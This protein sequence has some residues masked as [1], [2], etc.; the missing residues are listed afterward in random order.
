MRAWSGASGSPLGGGSKVTT[1][2]RICSTLRPVLADTATA[3]SAGQADGFLDHLLGARDVGRGQVDLVDDGDDLEAVRDGKV[4]IGEGLGFD[5]LA[6]V[7][8]Q[9]RAFTAGERARDFVAEVDVAGSVDE[10]E[11]VGFAVV[12]LVDH[13]DGVGLDGDAAFALEVH[14]VEDLGL[15]LALGQASGEL[16]EAVGEGGF[17]VVDVRDDREVADVAGV[18]S[19]VP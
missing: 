9:Q 14:G 10:V 4:S 1:A 18:H 8:H 11:L 5:A 2:S 12:R 13:A 16:E 7:D 19:W 3:S 15:H 17:A 6:C